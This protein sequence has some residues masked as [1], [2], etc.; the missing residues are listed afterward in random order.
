MSLT[1]CINNLACFF[2]LYCSQLVLHFI[3]DFEDR[4]TCHKYAFFFKN[5][6]SKF[7]EKITE[8]RHIL[9]MANVK[10]FIAI[11]LAFIQSSILAIQSNCDNC[12][13]FRI[14]VVLRPWSVI[15]LRFKLEC[16]GAML[17]SLAPLLVQYKHQT[18]ENN[19]RCKFPKTSSILKIILLDP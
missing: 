10:K 6:S 14:A 8:K 16:C 17:F 9:I 3:F 2:C 5:D 11:K 7:W 12:F 18:K 15:Q 13:V 19:Y 4:S 1:F